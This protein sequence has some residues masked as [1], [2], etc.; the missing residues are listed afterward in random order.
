MAPFAYGLER[1]FSS[2]AD[3]P[4]AGA[5]RRMGCPVSAT[6]FTAGQP[7]NEPADLWAIIE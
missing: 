4:A 1:C 5:R 2:A 3:H 6:T 7:F